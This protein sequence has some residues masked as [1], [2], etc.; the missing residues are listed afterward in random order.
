MIFSQFIQIIFAVNL[1]RHYRQKRRKEGREER[2]EERKGKRK[3]GKKRI[4]DINPVTVTET[5]T[6][7]SGSFYLKLCS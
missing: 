1:F 3:E 6:C 4:V 2:K 5:L 7:F